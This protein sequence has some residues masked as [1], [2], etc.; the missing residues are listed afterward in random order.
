MT[1]PAPFDPNTVQ[2][3]FILSPAQV[4]LILRGLGKL[5]LEETDQLYHGIRH[6]AENAIAQASQAA[7]DAAKAAPEAAKQAATPEPEP[8][9]QAALE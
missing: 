2:I 1:Q 4:G 5:P 8:L 9:P 3:Q 7:A 6:V